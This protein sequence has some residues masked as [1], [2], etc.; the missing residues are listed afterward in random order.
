M[1]VIIFFSF[2]KLLWN[3]NEGI[4]VLDMDFILKS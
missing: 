2:F 1:D 4:K 3:L